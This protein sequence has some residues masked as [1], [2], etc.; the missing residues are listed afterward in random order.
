[1]LL[2]PDS[3]TLQWIAKGAGGGIIVHAV[4]SGINALT[5]SASEPE[6]PG[7]ANSIPNDRE[8]D[9]ADLG[10][11]LLGLP[12]AAIMGGLLAWAWV[13]EGEERRMIMF[14]I[15]IPMFLH[16]VWRWIHIEEQLPAVGEAPPSDENDKNYVDPKAEALLAVVITGFALLP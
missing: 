2:L 3:E 15:S 14:A 7:A 11:F 12:F 16:A 6:P 13:S 8:Q 1:M 5:K 10:A 4:S 9:G